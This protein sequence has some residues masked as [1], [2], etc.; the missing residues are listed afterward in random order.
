[1]RFEL[2][3]AVWL[4]CDGQLAAVEEANLSSVNLKAIRW[5]ASAP[6]EPAPVAPHLS[7][8]ELRFR[9]AVWRR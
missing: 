5:F 4:T 9:A 6:P 3:D 2:N 8:S 7:G 1:V